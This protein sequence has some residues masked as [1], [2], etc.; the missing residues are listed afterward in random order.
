MRE[1]TETLRS[2]ISTVSGQLELLLASEGA[3]EEMTFTDEEERDS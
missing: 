3:V 1:L 2:I